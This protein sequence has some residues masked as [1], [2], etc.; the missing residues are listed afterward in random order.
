MLSGRAQ[1]R[2]FALLP[3]R[4][5]AYIKYLISSCGHQITTYRMSRLCVP[6]DY[7]WPQLV[8]K[9]ILYINTNWINIYVF[10]ILI[11]FQGLD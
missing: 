8:H 10:P 3:D 9:M 11:K 5:T 2:I 6:L 1:R 7:D 4:V